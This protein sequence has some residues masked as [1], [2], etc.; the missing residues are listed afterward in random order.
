[1]TKK[2]SSSI[3][4]FNFKVVVDLSAFKDDLIISRKAISV[5]FKLKFK[6]FFNRKPFR[7][8]PVF[9]LNFCRQFLSLSV[10][11]FV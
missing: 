10:F 4:C 11:F 6:L 9:K 1:M 7:E 2:A 3:S 5:L 8:F